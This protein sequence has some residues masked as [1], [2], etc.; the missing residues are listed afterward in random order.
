[1]LEVI[2]LECQRGDRR[3]FVDVSFSLEKSELLHIYG[4]NGSGK[5]TLMRAVCGLITPAGGSIRWA[6][7]R[8][9]KQRDEFAAELVYLGHKNGI[10]D[11]L[12]GVE[13]LLVA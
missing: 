12:T 9:H 11:D 4:H 1:M 8:I 13:N 3:L 10:K 2:D 6:G 7:E 5:T